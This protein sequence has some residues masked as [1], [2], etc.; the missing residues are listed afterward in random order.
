MVVLTVTIAKHSPCKAF[1][2]ALSGVRKAAFHSF[3]HCDGPFFSVLDLVGIKQRIWDKLQ[4]KQANNFGSLSYQKQKNFGSLAQ[5]LFAFST[6]HI[7][8]VAAI[9]LLF[10]YDWRIEMFRAWP[11]PK[12]IK[13]NNTWVRYW[14][15][16]IN[17]VASM[18]STNH[19][20]VLFLL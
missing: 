3:I 11:Q 13:S 4:D 2:H 7:H 8:G 16:L 12:L 1:C 10:V 6:Q 9:F 17:P 18:Q 19:P 5:G 14:I 20:K 15:N